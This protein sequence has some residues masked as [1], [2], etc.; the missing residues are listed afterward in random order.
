MNFL[1]VVFHLC[2][3]IQLFMQYA[4]RAEKSVKGAEAPIAKSAVAA[5]GS[6]AWEPLIALK[7][8]LG[9]RFREGRCRGRRGALHRLLYGS[10]RRCRSG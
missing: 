8:F 10:A 7:P 1:S 3:E 5:F 6:K 9:L 4:H 2:G